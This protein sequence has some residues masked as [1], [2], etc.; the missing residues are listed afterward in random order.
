MIQAR[1]FFRYDVA[2]SATLAALAISVLFHF[3]VGV[4]W[5]ATAPLVP[6]LRHV[7]RQIAP[8]LWLPVPMLILLAGAGYVVFVEALGMQE[9]TLAL[10]PLS[11]ALAAVAGV[12]YVVNGHLASKPAPS[13]PQHRI[14]R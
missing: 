1:K 10:M 7:L 9:V 13:E 14:R 12:A 2:L 3:S 6:L 5:I 8:P 11:C 4:A